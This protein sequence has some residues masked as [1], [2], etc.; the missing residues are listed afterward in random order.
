M[1]TIADGA[2]GLYADFDNRFLARDA[3][4]GVTR[5]ALSELPVVDVSPF[6]TPSDA[7]ARKAV[8]REL[9][10]ACIDI[11]FFYAVGHGMSADDIAECHDWTRRFF[12]LPRAEKE[13]VSRLRSPTRMGWRGPGASEGYGAAGKGKGKEKAGG[14]R[15]ESLVWVRRQSVPSELKLHPSGA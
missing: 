10:K 6:V 2:V 13:K 9:R 3:A 8:A 7:A 1:E 12:E 4:S 5:A 14:R 11:G 15:R